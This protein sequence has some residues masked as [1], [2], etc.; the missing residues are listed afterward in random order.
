MLGSFQPKSRVTGDKVD[1]D[2]FLGRPLLVRVMDY[3]PE[4]TSQ[5]YPNPK[6][7]VFVDVVD[8]YSGSIFINA[9]WGSGAIVD[10]L[11]DGV[12]TNVAVPVQIVKRQGKNAY[13]TLDAIDPNL[14]QAASDWYNQNWASVDAERARR[15]AAATAAAAQAPAQQGFGAPA[16]NQAPAQQGFGAP[17]AAGGGMFSDTPPAP[18]QGQGFG[19]PQGTNPAM[20][21]AALNQLTGQIPPG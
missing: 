20:A 19:A 2:Q 13:Y 16:Q 5:Q 1:Y 21:Q 3:T 4:F 12:G 18:A 14:L 9:L 11:K 7:V 17:A 8:L 15:E 10:N 6:P